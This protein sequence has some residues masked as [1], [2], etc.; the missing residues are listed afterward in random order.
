VLADT[1]ERVH[2][3]LDALSRRLGVDEFVIDA[4]TTDHAARLASVE[5]LGGAQTITPAHIARAATHGAPSLDRD[6]PHP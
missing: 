2:R 4:P 3:A 6:T 5:W 1:P